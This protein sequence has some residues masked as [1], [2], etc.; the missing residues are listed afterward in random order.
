MMQAAAEVIVVADSTKLGRQSLTHLCPLD[1]VQHMV[2]DKGITPEWREKLQ[3]AGIDLI[4]A[5][6][7][8]EENP[9]V[10]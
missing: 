9:T 3:A 4:V 2:V 8:P 5:D 7:N 1:A 10:R 6:A